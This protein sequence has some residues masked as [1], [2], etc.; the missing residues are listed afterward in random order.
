MEDDAKV[1]PLA[2]QFKHPHPPEL[3][4]VRE[5]QK[6]FHRQ[7]LVDESKAAVECA[8]CHEKL[9]PMWVLSHLAS[10]NSR[11]LEASRRY[12]DEMARLRER[13]RTK[14][15]HCGQMTRISTR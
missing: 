7:F 9:N 8:D 12:Q 1:V 3:E 14:C 13:S 15:Q 11:F 4:L 10:E 2:V 5:Y 6:C